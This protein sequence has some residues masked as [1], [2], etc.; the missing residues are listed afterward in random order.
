MGWNLGT[1]LLQPLG[2][3]QSAVR[4]GPGYV[5]RAILRSFGS[6]VGINDAVKDMH[7]KSIFMRL[8]AKTMNR[9]INEIRN[10][11]GRTSMGSRLKDP[12]DNS[13]FYLIAKAQLLADVPTWLGAYDKAQAENASEE[14]SIARADQAVIDSQGSGHIKDLADV[15]R[16]GPLKKIWTNFMSYFQTTFNLTADSFTRT[17]FNS[18]SSVMHLGVDLLLLY[19]LPIVLEEYVRKALIQGECDDGRDFECMLTKIGLDHLAYGIGG[20]LFA[21]EFGGLVQGFAD[22]DGPAGARVFKDVGQFVN[23]AM[24]GEADDKFYLSALKAGGIA[25]HFPAGAMQ[26]FITGYLDLQSGKTDKV[27][28]PLFGYSK[29]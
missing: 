26:K 6:L 25:L 16:G 3:T 1:S 27:T 5:G 9:E 14:D 12:L 22:Y 28:A 13:F 19:S 4:I 29:K 20:I 10:K 2:L 17:K 7:E 15:Q 18:P 23:Q 11:I 24:Q 21:R 8:R